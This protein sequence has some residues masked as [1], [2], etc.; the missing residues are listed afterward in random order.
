VNSPVRLRLAPALALLAFSQF[1]IAIDYNIVYVALPDIGRELGFSTRSLQWVVSAYLVGLGGFLLLGGRAVDRFGQRRLF[2][3]GLALYGAASLAGGLAVDPGMLIGA[4]AVQGLGGALLTPATLALLSTIFAEGPERHRAMGVWGTT[5]GSGLAAGALLG[6][7]LTSALGWEWV[8]FVN[9]PLALAG[10]VAAPRLLPADAPRPSTRGGFDM[11][12]ALV[13]TLGASLLVFGL[14]SGPDS[15]WGTIRG[16]GA[17]AGGVGLLA[18]FFLIERHVRDPLMPLRLLRIQ[19]LVKAMAVMFIFMGSLSGEYYLFTVY[20]QDVLGYDALAAGLAFVPLTL[21]SMMSTQRLAALLLGRWG[22]RTTL[23]AGLLV[24]GIGMVAFTIGMTAGGSYWTLLPGIVIWGTGG[25][26]YPTMFVVAASGLDPTE[27]GIASGLASTSMQIGGAIGLA[28]IVAIAN[29]TGQ[30]ATASGI[31]NG[32]RPAGWVAGASLIVAVAIAVTLKTPRA[33]A[34]P[35][36]NER[37][38]RA[39]RT[40]HARP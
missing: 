33:V 20:L 22:L 15:G 27:Q 18:V 39:A 11:P 40:E 23:W 38:S 5:G 17:L 4:R 28:A 12:G 29:T 26:T 34:A 36:I 25:F 35:S 21:I 13:A 2:I 19:S 7:V 14:A 30:P 37:N 1:V 10:V 8:F 24:N 9:V 16:A 3:F 6:G 31:V 32:L